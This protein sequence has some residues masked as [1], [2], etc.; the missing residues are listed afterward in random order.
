MDKI[1]IVATV[2]VVIGIIFAVI[3]FKSNKKEEGFAGIL[4]SNGITLIL[5]SAPETIDKLLVLVG[6]L[7]K[8]ENA[9]TFAGDFNY[10]YFIVGILLVGLSIYL[11]I[12]S[13]K[14]IYVLNIN[15]YMSKR[16]ENYF[17]DL[18]MSNFDFKEREV[19]FIKIYKKMFISNLNEDSFECIKEEIEEKVTAFKHESN[20]VKRGYTGIA[21]IPF[22][23]YAGTYLNRV[24]I[25][26]Y[27][28]FD[29]KITNKYYSL[30]S[31]KK[32]YPKLKLKTDLNQ[33][34]VNKNEVLMAISLTQSIE[35]NVLTQFIPNC[36]IVRIEVDNPEDNTIRNKKQL[37][38]YVDVIIKAI[39]NIKRVIP[40][41]KVNLVYSGQSCLALELGKVFFDDTRMPEV[42]NYHYDFQ[43]QV[44]K[45]PWGIIINGHNKGKLI[46]A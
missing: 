20:G 23:M 26:E 17:K 6:I 22:I 5:A 3:K 8:Y 24:N 40:N 29:K 45:Y 9:E 16:L 27:Y 32:T 34:D 10:Y 13:K 2:I 35:D 19:D 46:K 11:N 1:V 30:S 12:Y 42:T 43:N 15:G 28:E 39:E 31:K 21:P 7:T 14:K 41:L 18:K 36:N 44:T 38:E 33:L 25:D 37:V 4:F